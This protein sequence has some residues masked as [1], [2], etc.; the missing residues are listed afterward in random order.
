MFCLALMKTLLGTDVD[1]DFLNRTV[2]I[3]VELDE[4]GWLQHD[5]ELG[6]HVL[7]HLKFFIGLLKR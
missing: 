7:A 6:Q 4:A 3:V 5:L 2:G 1:R